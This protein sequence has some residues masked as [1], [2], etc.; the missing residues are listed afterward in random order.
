M[1]KNRSCQEG[2]IVFGDWK[3]FPLDDMNWELCH[4]HETADTESARKAGN[5]G[6]LAWHRLGRYY[7]ANTFEGSILYAADVELKDRCKDVAIQLEDAL[8]EHER[9][10]KL[11]MEEFT[12]SLIEVNR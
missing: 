8:R 9:I 4:R 3:L 11:M 12:A 10:V 7:Q 5:V 6:K 2:G 1:A